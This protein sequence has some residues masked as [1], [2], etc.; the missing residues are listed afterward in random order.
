MRRVTRKLAWLIS[1][2]PRVDRYTMQDRRGTKFSRSLNN[3]TG[4]KTSKKKNTFFK[5]HR[6]LDYSAPRESPSLQFWRCKSLADSLAR[7][8]C[9]SPT[10]TD[11]PPSL[12]WVASGSHEER[13]CE[14]RM[15][16][17]PSISLSASSLS[18]SITLLRRCDAG[19]MGACVVLCHS[20]LLFSKIMRWKGETHKQQD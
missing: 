16:Q 4:V 19:R 3:K 15:T 10:H 9:L 2:D 5:Y 1:S 20:G 6:Y 11:T 13:K 18:A 7:P 12:L 14:G 8:I 17:Q